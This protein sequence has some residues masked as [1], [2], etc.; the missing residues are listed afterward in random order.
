MVLNYLKTSK[1]YQVEILHKNNRYYVYVTIEESPA[2]AYTSYNG[3]LGAD[4]NP[5]GLGIADVDHLGQFRGSFWVPQG[6]WTYARTAR[7]MNLIGEAA[8][9]LVIRAKQSGKALAIEDLKFRDDKSISSKFNRMS[10]GFVWSKF[11]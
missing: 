4:T 9:E 8:R 1:A 6:E 5:D 2:E 7:R 10:H 3:V 11:L